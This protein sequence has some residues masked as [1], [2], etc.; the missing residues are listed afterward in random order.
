MPDL[1]VSYEEVGNVPEAPLPDSE[2]WCFSVEKATSLQTE[3]ARLSLEYGLCE[4]TADRLSV[5][6]K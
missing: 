6:Q 3:P 4:G 5:T 1:K 2:V